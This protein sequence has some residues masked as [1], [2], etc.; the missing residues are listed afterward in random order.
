MKRLEF[1]GT[2]CEYLDPCPYKNEKGT[3][4]VL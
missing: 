3:P 2:W 4:E 1:H